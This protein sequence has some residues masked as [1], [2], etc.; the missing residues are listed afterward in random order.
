L[1]LPRLVN[2]ESTLGCN[3][4]CV[5][6]GSH[7]SGVTKVRRVMEPELLA[8]V[9]TQAARRAID[10]SL[11][12]AG[13]PLMTP[14]L[15]QFVAVAE[16]T[17]AALQL[18]TNGT[19]LKDDPT[20]RRI[21][22]QSSEIRV[23]IDAPDAGVYASIRGK[24]DLETVLANT[25]LLVRLAHAGPRRPIIAIAMVL[26]RRNAALLPQMVDLAHGLGADRLDVAH[27]TVLDEAMDAESLR[28]DPAGADAA[29]AA[30]A[31][32]ADALGFRVS[33]PP[34]M[35]AP[36]RPAGLRARARRLGRDL[37]RLDAARVA[38]VGRIAAHTLA[39]RVWELR[40]GGRVP[41]HFL[42]GAAFVSIGGDVSPCPMPGRPVAGNLL[43]QDFDAI[44][45]GPV[46][47]AMRQGF[48]DGRPF[49]CCR[50]C[51]QNPRGYRPD[52]PATVRP[53]GYTLPRVGRRS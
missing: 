18:N 46:L 12:V 20:L 13:E 10:L 35:A 4:E 34:P 21:L 50:H 41:C 32:R 36:P 25:R 44:W 9:E 30:A 37:A 7:L 42:R 26:M 2:V 48:I 40:A 27:L 17:G 1:P 3:L 53:R 45:N 5:M 23:S 14:R 33:L 28:H 19:L 52:D 38:R 47:S 43:Q 29:L 6:C 51:S 8:R 15:S 22:A 39:T 49:D 24:A 11:T 31:L 16:R